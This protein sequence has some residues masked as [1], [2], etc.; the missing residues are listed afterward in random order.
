MQISLLGVMLPI[1]F[2]S[3]H[4]SLLS[5]N[6]MHMVCRVLHALNWIQVCSILKFSLV[7]FVDNFCGGF[8]VF[9]FM[10]LHLQ[11]KQRTLVAVECAQEKSCT[12]LLVFIMV[13]RIKEP[14]AAGGLEIAFNF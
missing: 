8:M 6:L 1:M 3:T 2:P 7:A 5:W 9:I 12:L 11:L 4:T 13:R 14:A 10:S